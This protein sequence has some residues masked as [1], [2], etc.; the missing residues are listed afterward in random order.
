MKKH[1]ILL[2]VVVILTTLAA[3]PISYRMTPWRVTGDPDVPLLPD[4]SNPYPYANL[5]FVPHL[6]IEDSIIFNEYNPT[7]NTITDAGATLGRV[8]F[9]DKTLSQNLTISCGSCHKAEDGFSDA[10]RLSVGF[11]GDSTTRN[12]MGLANARFQPTGRFFW[13]ASADTLRNQ[14]RLALQSPIEMGMEMDTLIARVANK[15]YYPPLFQEAFGT[16]TVTEERISAAIGQFVRSMFSFR[17]KYDLGVMQV[18]DRMV[19]FPNYTN[20]ENIGKQIFFSNQARCSSCHTTH[21]FHMT[22]PRNNGLEMVY[23]DKGV[24]EHTQLAAD[25]GKFKAAS[26]RNIALTAPYM[27]DGRFQ[28]LEEVVEHYNSGVQ[29][30]PNL[31]PI[32]KDNGQPYAPNLTQG[33]KDALV[34]FLKTLTD[35]IFLQDPRWENPFGLDTIRPV[36]GD[37]VFL[38]ILRPGPENFVKAYPNPFRESL[39]VEWANPARNKFNLKIFA[40]GGQQVRDYSTHESEFLIQR[41]SLPPGNYILEINNGLERW[42]K[43]LSVE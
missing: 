9:Y 38:P 29:N 32:L 40:V 5:P 6:F 3:I 10:N 21:N 14:V 20:L 37:S 18:W 36:P 33:D 12:S 42:I 16:P 23:A 41:E 39:K 35:E 1:L 24:G 17:T 31:D 15:D 22:A 43:K 8:L 28:T 30:H 7:D 25:N 4:P 2:S 19:P 13:D 26:L 34:A 27:H 11:A